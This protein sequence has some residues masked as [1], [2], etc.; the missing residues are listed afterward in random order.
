MM[1][2]FVPFLQEVKMAIK[3]I[4]PANFKCFKCYYFFHFP[5]YVGIVNPKEPFG[6][7]Y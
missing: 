1:F 5:Q 3:R 4:I 6:P 7:K 2:V